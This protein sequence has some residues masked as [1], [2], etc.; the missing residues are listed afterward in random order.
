MI[1]KPWISANLK[2]NMLQTKEEIAQWLD[3]QY[4][5]KYTIN[6]DLTVDVDCDTSLTAK[7]LTEIPVQF[8]NINGFF[9]CSCNRLTTLKGCPKGIKS[10]FACDKN[11][12]KSLK[13]LPIILGKP[14]YCDDYLKSSNEYKSY[15]L[16][17]A[18]RK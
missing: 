13:Y 6:N 2:F 15:I 11:K 4:I 1:L 7:E 14:L 9:S 10:F 8:N 17:N 16:L 5:K 12:L 3:C 18:L